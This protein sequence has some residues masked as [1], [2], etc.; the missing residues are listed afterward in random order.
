MH[1]SFDCLIQWTKDNNNNKMEQCA[2]LS[3]HWEQADFI[4]MLNVTWMRINLLSNIPRRVYG[5]SSSHKRK[6][7]NSEL[8]LPYCKT[9]LEWINV[10]SVNSLLKSAHCSKLT[11]LINFTR[12]W[13]GACY[14]PLLIKPFQ[15]KICPSTFWVTIN[16]CF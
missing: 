10:S 8:F 16:L 11:E 14:F 7:L 3:L 12:Y 1:G 15:G 13:S 4:W 5:V 6:Q 9:R 2:H